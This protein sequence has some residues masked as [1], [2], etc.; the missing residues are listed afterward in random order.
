MIRVLERQPESTRSYDEVKQT[1]MAE[2]GRFLEEQ[3]V[4]AKVKEL[5]ATAKIEVLDSRFA[6]PPQA[7]AQPPAAKPPTP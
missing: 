5:A 2:M 4:Q 7:Q 3:I 6:P 1:L